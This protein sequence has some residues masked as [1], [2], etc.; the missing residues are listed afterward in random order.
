[1]KHQ[2]MPS[3]ARNPLLPLVL[4]CVL[5]VSAQERVPPPR[6][7]AVLPPPASPAIPASL[8]PPP[9]ALRHAD[10]TTFDIN[11]PGNTPAKLVEMIARQTGKPLNT[12]I[13]PEY[14]DTEL[15]PLNLHGVTVPQ[16]FEA[17]EQASR[18]KVTYSTGAYGGGLGGYQ[19]YQ[20]GTSAF[21]FRTTGP[22]REDSIWHF[23]VEMPSEPPKPQ[24]QNP[25]PSKPTVCRFFQLS[26]Y[27]EHGLKVED[28]TTALETAWK[29]MGENSVPRIKFH[30]D[31]KLLIAVG[32]ADK[33]QLIDEVLEKLPGR[34]ASVDSIPRWPR[35][36]KP[37]NELPSLPPQ[38]NG[39][40]PESNNPK[41]AKP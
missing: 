15:P 22:A 21:G 41:P 30:Q 29:M 23:F 17:L 39:T 24:E 33:L 2:P 4:A 32:H 27:L 25:A 34:P 13:P 6:L 40:P 19:S 31:T 5:N 8:S 1:M 38:P 37:R 3:L 18:K 36:I 9:I 10:F 35:E 12:I 28:I 20:Q 16:L 26:P 7:P 11:F 14:A